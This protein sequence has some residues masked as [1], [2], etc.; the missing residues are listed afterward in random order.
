M[1]E[2][3]EEFVQRILAGNPQVLKM[4]DDVAHHHDA[5]SVPIDPTDPTVQA[6]YSTMLPAPLQ[7]IKYQRARP[8]QRTRDSGS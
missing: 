8:N 2:V 7:N 4:L 6:K 3:V 1:Q 5:T